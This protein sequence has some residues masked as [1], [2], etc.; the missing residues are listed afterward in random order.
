MHQ[1][2]VPGNLRRTA[3]A[4]TCTLRTA[5]LVTS[6]R[7]S[8]IAIALALKPGG[9]VAP[10]EC[11]AEDALVSI[12]ATHKL[13]QAQVKEQMRAVGWIWAETVDALPW[14]HL[15]FFSLGAAPVG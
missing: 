7:P 3:T 5:D 12:R 4:S 11:R 6:H 14:Q 2:P 15:V 1:R 9:P 13:G 8:P 10:I